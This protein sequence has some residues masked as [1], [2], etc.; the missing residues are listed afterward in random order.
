[1]AIERIEAIPFAIPNR[2]E[3]GKIVSAIWTVDAARHVLVKITDSDGVV[4]YGEATPRATIYGDTQTSTVAIIRDWIEP[5]LRGLEPW[6]IEDAWTRM[7]VFPHNLPAKAAI[8]EA[9]HDIQGKRLGVN[10]RQL[11]GGMNR[12]RCPL[13]T[14]IPL[15]TP[16]ETAARCAAAVSSGIRFLKVKIGKDPARD[17]AA[18]RAIRKAVGGEVCVSVDINQGYAAATAIRVLNALQEFGIAWAEEP[19]KAWDLE[20][21]LQVA[22]SVAVPLLLDESAFTPQEVVRQITN[23]ACGMISIKGCRTGFFRSRAVASIAEAHN[24]PCV[25]GSA[26]EST[27]GTLVAAYVGASCRSVIASE[28]GDH[29]IFEA[30][31]LTKWPRIEDGY[32]VLPDGPGLGVEIDEAQVERY[33]IDR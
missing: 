33:R 27:L 26:R 17:I 8:D 31:L 25:I 20:G 4:G 5:S 3:V 6:A 11:L 21:K 23:G 7:D 32:L 1:M 22:K 19:V 24:I 28:I 29:V 10:V 13:G 18:V 15:G 12:D 9:L 16:D 14:I 30:S 2:P